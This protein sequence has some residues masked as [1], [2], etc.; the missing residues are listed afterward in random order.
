MII[1]HTRQFAQTLNAVAIFC[2]AAGALLAQSAG[3]L[4][5]T[6]TDPTGAVVPNAEVSIRN[7]QTGVIVRAETNAQGLFRV[8][9][10]PIG[11]YELSVTH[12]GFEKLVRSGVEML[13][14]RV[15]DVPLELKV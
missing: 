4:T 2:L 7:T 6:I 14:G 3:I 13:T 10:V 15:I 11:L 8:P 1:P 9:D 12:P 5:G